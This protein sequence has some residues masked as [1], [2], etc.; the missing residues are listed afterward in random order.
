MSNWL[1][2]SL[3]G[4][5]IGAVTALWS[6]KRLM[7][8]PSTRIWLSDWINWSNNKLPHDSYQL[9][10]HGKWVADSHQNEDA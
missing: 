6:I 9:I 5:I 8:Q 3:I 1:M 4:L 10:R 7:A 2:L